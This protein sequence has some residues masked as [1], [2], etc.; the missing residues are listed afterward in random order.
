[1]Q[2]IYLFVTDTA[3]D[4][5]NAMILNTRER[6]GLVSIFIHWLM[7]IAIL[8][9]FG[10]GWYMVDLTYYDPLYK[11]LPFIHKSVGILL[12]LV[13]IFRLLWKWR[14]PMPD[15]VAGSS[16][17]ENKASKL[18]HSGMYLLIALI[19]I[20]GYLISTAEGA[21]IDVFELFTVPATVTSIPEQEDNAGLVHE[22]LAYALIG[23]VLAHALAALKH[24]FVNKD[25]TL[26]RMLG[27]GLKDKSHPPVTTT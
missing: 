7:A 10:L 3:S 4:A 23:L 26:R 22:Y 18:A 20:S 19:M 21:G 17:W 11:T 12:A 16:R 5:T 24:H 15:P 27:V 8:G 25:H 13:F 14:N 2:Y 6:F 1:M 9:L